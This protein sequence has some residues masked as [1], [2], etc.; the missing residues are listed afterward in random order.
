MSRYSNTI[1]KEEQKEIIVQNDNSEEEK[2]NKLKDSLTYE[3]EREAR[4]KFQKVVA[5]IKLYGDVRVF[6]F[7]QYKISIVEVMLKH[8]F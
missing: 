4:K 1:D 7:T 5:L 2:W 3:Q 8:K 6:N